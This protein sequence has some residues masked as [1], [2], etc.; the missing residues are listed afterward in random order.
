MCC[1]RTS[2]PSNAVR[3]AGPS[4]PVPTHRMRQVDELLRSLL[5]NLLERTL[6]FP[7]GVVVTITRVQTAADLSSAQVWVSVLPVEQ[8]TACLEQIRDALPELQRSVA[9]TVAFQTM[10]RLQLMADASGERADHI[11]GL[12][13]SLKHDEP[14]RDG[15]DHEAA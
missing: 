1:K 12:L 2:A 5:A 15:H 8:R 10:P 7:V 9:Q 3:S 11:T 13:D 4:K 6:E 14:R